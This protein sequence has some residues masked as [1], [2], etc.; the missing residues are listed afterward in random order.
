MAD[1]VYGRYGAADVHGDPALDRSPCCQAANCS[2]CDEQPDKCSACDS[3]WTLL[4][5]GN[6]T[7][8]EPTA[9]APVDAP[10]SSNIGLSVLAITGIV[11]IVL[12]LW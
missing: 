5:D 11:L 6:C 1:T 12:A 2:A 10:N 4:A 7:Q 3:G 8:T 9:E